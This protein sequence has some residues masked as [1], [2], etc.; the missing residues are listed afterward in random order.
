MLS[1]FAEKSE[2][3]GRYDRNRI[4]ISAGQQERIRSYRVFIGGAGIGSLVAECALRLGFEHIT[5]VD[6]DSAEAIGGRLKTTYAVAIIA[7]V[8]LVDLWG[9]DKRYLNDSHF[10][11]KS[12]TALAYQA[13][14]ADKYILQDKGLDYR[15]LNLAVSTFNDNTTSYYHKSIGGYHAA[16]LRRYQEMIEHHIMPDMTA[17]HRAIY[18]NGGDL[19]NVDGRDFQVLNMLN[20]KYVIMPT[21]G[22]GVTA[23]PNPHCMGNAWFVNEVQYVGNANEEIDAIDSIDVR[24][25]AVV[26]HRFAASLG[27]WSVAADSVP[28]TVQAGLTLTSYAPNRLV[29]KATADVDRV[30]VFSEIYYPDWTATIDGQPVEI[31][32]ADYILRALRIPAGQHEIVFTFEPVSIRRTEAAAYTALGLLVAGVAWMAVSAAR[33]R[34]REAKSPA[35]KS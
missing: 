4:Y 10:V 16:K 24:T 17:M 15:V 3:M 5:V 29:Y 8:C 13:T 21:A 6:M 9:V 22:G 30:A 23:L 19:T 18:E 35:T 11:H 2:I 20:T 25:T 28:K 27:D 1:T 32:R 14:D 33:R 12:E 31:A 34:R 26:D 7:A